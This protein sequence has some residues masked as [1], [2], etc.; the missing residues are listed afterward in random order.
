M[1]AKNCF[2]ILCI[3]KDSDLNEAKRAY[4]RLVKRWHP[5]QYGNLPEKQQIA[6]E[7]LT[8]INVAYREIVSILKNR[9]DSP[10]PMV[11]SKKTSRRPTDDRSFSEKKTPLWR[12][13]VSFFSNSM[14]G[15][16]R[17]VHADGYAHHTS[18]GSHPESAAPEF[19][20]AL[21]QAIH[22]QR[23]NAGVDQRS[24]RAKSRARGNSAQR[25]RGRKTVYGTHVSPRRSSGERIEKIRPVGRVKKIG[26]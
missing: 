21:K 20:Q 17:T 26:D 3:S 19:R 9:I 11:E 1:D 18:R 6:H 7:K 16:R 12:R 23:R 4:K 5:D 14:H 10:G 22:K 15:A 25:G 24:A 13:I 8:E 2:D